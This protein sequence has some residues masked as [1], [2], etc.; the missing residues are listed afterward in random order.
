MLDTP[1]RNILGSRLSSPAQNNYHE[2]SL[3]SSA[4]DSTSVLQ[5]RLDDEIAR[6]KT[7]ESTY[8]SLTKFQKQ[9]SL[10]METI[11]E[12]RKDLEKELF[13]K[14]SELKVEKQ[15]RSQDRMQWKPK[16]EMMQDEHK[17][18]QQALNETQRQKDELKRKVEVDLAQEIAQL[19][20][21]LVDKEQEQAQM[22]QTYEERLS[23]LQDEHTRQELELQSTRQKQELEQEQRLQAMEVQLKAAEADRDQARD[24]VRDCNRDG[25]V[26]LCV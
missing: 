14:E 2:K 1:A 25:F 11:T 10:Q 21:Q 13:Q 12:S 22:S 6:R 19:K 15:A 4:G 5:K 20:Q 23:N 9:Q 24:E 7:L 8:D 3:S 18:L 16:I 26:V 17:R